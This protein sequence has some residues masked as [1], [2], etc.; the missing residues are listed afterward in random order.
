MIALYSNCPSLDLHGESSDYARIAI[1]DFVFDN[2][3][4]K[5]E[6]IVIIHGIGSGILKKT[7]QETLRY[8]KYVESYKIDNFN[9]GQTIVKL[10]RKI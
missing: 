2:Y 6:T 7:T 9:D 5:Y 1:N 4:M 8:N 3:K 10:R